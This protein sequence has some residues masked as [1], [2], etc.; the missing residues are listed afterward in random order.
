MYYKDKEERTNL[1]YKKIISAQLRKKHAVFR[2]KTEVTEDLVK[3][4]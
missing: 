3:V 2:D 4:R 1:D